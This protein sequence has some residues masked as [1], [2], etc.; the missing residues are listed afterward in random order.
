[1][2]FS[3]K[4]DLKSRVVGERN[5]LTGEFDVQENGKAFFRASYVWADMPDVGVDVI[6]NLLD[7]YLGEPA[8]INWSNKTIHDV[9]NAERKIQAAINYLNLVGTDLANAGADSDNKKRA[10]EQSLAKKG[11][12]PKKRR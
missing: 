11:K 12:K 10:A 5:E 3:I 7:E 9:L 6:E 1:M 4:V 2:P 8:P